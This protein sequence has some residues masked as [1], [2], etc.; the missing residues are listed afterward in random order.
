MAAPENGRNDLPWSSLV[1]RQPVLMASGT[2]RGVDWLKPVGGPDLCVI[3]YWTLH[4]SSDPEHGIGYVSEGDWVCSECHECFIIG[5]EL[6]AH[7]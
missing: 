7:E 2:L 4:E 6:S 5:T 1:V 3:C